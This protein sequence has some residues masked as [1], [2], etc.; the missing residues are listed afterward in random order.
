MRSLLTAIVSG[1]LLMAAFATDTQAANIL[2][3]DSAAGTSLPPS[4]QGTGVTGDNLA[5]GPGLNSASG[6]SFNSNN[7]TVDG[8]LADAII[9]QDF[10]SWG[11]T[12]TTPYDLD[13]LSIR[14]DRSPTGPS[15]IAIQASFNGGPFATIFTDDSVSASGETQLINLFGPPSVSSA[16]FRLYGFQADGTTGTFDIE[17]DGNFV[18]SADLLIT[19]S[20]IPEPSRTMLVGLAGL[21][22]LLHRRRIWHQH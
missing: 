22:A 18:G 2:A 13:R 1:S 10:L 5:R 21:A 12:S 4:I 19:G 3:Y 6:S 8:T 20:I 11:F 16:Q 15:E 17:P 9:N 14:Y 7:W